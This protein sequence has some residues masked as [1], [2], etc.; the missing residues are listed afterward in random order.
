[1]RRGRER[2]EEMCRAAILAARA[3]GISRA[4]EARL[5]MLV[6]ESG[7]ST[8]R[9]EA[10]FTHNTDWLW[11]QLNVFAPVQPPSRIGSR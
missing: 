10:Q 2:R 3:P 8:E 6:N 9:D 7:P 5:S 11:V 1:M 4:S